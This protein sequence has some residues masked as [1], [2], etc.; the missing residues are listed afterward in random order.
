[1]EPSCSDD[2]ST[3]TQSQP[4]LIQTS[5]NTSP[6]PGDRLRQPEPAQGVCVRIGAQQRGAESD[7]QRSSTAERLPSNVDA[8]AA[9]S[10]SYDVGESLSQWNEGEEFVD[11]YD[12]Q[13]CLRIPMNQ[14]VS[15]EKGYGGY[16]RGDRLVR[17][18]S[19]RTPKDDGACGGSESYGHVSFRQ[20]S[21]SD[22]ADIVPGY[23]V[24]AEADWPVT[25]DSQ[26][27]VRAVGDSVAGVSGRE[28]NRISPL[29]QSVGKFQ[30]PPN[31]R[32]NAQ[33]GS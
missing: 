31:F 4:A 32:A 23:W 19:V 25:T 11:V 8:E 5:N 30:R 21:R 6:V 15:N 3:R 27:D 2:I 24:A 13:V 17:R 22:S 1:M 18:P 7:V 28:R 33:C 14:L 20:R 26:R 9:A 10:S 12:D 16:G 29:E